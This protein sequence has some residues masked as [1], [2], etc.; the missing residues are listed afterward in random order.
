MS[1]TKKFL[2]LVVTYIL[3]L[4]AMLFFDFKDGSFDLSQKKGFSEI[5]SNNVMVTLN[6]ILFGTLSFGV[7]SLVLIIFNAIILVTTIKLGF[8]R[9]GL[10]VFAGLLPHGIFEI[11]A[12]LLALVIVWNINSL[13]VYKLLNKRHIDYRSILN[14]NLNLFC[15]MIFLLFI[16]AWIESNFSHML[17]MRL[18]Q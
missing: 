9:W 14:N 18:T 17:I 12:N 1:N 6:I 15:G 13:I 3:L 11:S 16:G 7:I 8:S 2:L 5:L 4:A 10:S